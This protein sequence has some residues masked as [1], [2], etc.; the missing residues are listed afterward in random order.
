MFIGGP[1]E[2]VGSDFGEDLFRVLNTGIELENGAVN[3]NSRRL[4]FGEE[5]RGKL[6]RREHPEGKNYAEDELSHT[7]WLLIEYGASTL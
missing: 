6:K 7:L 3:Q 2:G 1:F 4:R 5:P